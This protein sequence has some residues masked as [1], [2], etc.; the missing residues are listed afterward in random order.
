MSQYRITLKGRAVGPGADW[1]TPGARQILAYAAGLP[2][3]Q[4]F[5]PVDVPT[6][7]ADGPVAVQLGLH[8]LVGSGL[9]A[10]KVEERTEEATRG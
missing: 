6:A 7:T 1:L 4:R 9:L 2:D 8:E 5:S 3:G 10:R